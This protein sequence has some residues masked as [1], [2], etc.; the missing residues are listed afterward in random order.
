[1]RVLALVKDLNHVCCRYRLAA[2]QPYFTNAGHGFQTLVWPK[3]WW[4]FLGM[5]KHLRQ[6]D[7]LIVQRRLLSPWQLLL[8]RRAGRR[9][10]FDFDDAVF[11]RDSYAEAG[12]AS[13]SRQ[14]GFRRMVRAADF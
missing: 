1:M 3:P 4:R 14:R 9:L 12:Q 8:V 7:V 6:A 5:Q 11:M 13:P 10:I 2:F